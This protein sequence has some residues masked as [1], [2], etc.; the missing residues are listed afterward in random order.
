MVAPGVPIWF[1]LLVVIIVAAVVLGAA[2]HASAKG[3][4]EFGGLE[5]GRV[6]A[7]FLSRPSSLALI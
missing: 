6:G 5:V 3:S 2:R 7:A 1:V 4:Q